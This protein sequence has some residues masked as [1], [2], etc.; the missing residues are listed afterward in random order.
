MTERYTVTIPPRPSVHTN[1]PWRW[2][3]VKD[4]NSG[5]SVTVGNHGS[6]H[7]SREAAIAVLE[8]L[9]VKP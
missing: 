9:A 4:N 3:T 2:V 8:L 5:N 7:K 6:Q 1:G